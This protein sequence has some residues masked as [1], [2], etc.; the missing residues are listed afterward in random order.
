MGVNSR[1]FLFQIL[2]AAPCRHSQFFLFK[3]YY[4]GVLCSACGHYVRRCRGDSF[5]TEG[6][7]AISLSEQDTSLRVR[8]TGTAVHV[9]D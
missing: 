7:K 8:Y 3:E 2:P 4:I 5:Q 9:L 1:R 6:Q